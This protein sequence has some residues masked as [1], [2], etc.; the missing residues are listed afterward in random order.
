MSK[1]LTRLPARPEEIPL[2]ILGFVKFGLE[3]ASIVIVLLPCPVLGLGI[4]IA[5]TPDREGP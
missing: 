2:A 1:L 4:A 5:A 3:L